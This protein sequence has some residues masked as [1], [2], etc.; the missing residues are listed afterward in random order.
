MDITDLRSEPIKSKMKP[1][2]LYRYYDGDILVGKECVSCGICFTIDNYHNAKD[3]KD[4]TVSKCKQCV[5]AQVSSSYA[6]RYDKTGA[7]VPG[8]V[9][10]VT[11]GTDLEGMIAVPSRRYRGWQG[12][13][14]YNS[15]GKIV[16]K[17]CPEC[18]KAI[19][20]GLFDRN[21]GHTDGLSTYCKKCNGSLNKEYASIRQDNDPNYAKNRS[22]KSYEKYFLRTDEEI[23]IKRSS[24]HPEGTKR[25]RVCR[26][27]RKFTEY[28]IARGR[29]DGLAQDCK[30]C[31]VTKRRRVCEEY[32]KIA[33]I[34]L[35]C[36]LDS[37]SK[38]FEEIDHVV[39]VTL[40]G[41]DDL[42]NLLPI[43]S[44]HNKRKHGTL[45]PLWLM[46]DYPED[47]RSTMETVEGYGIDTWGSYVPLVN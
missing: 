40:D 45:L 15:D 8:W 43:C 32:W 10:E 27:T 9:E 26:G 19:A 35:V 16:G 44:H 17:V 2:G 1:T 14:F 41:S 23:A 42:S 38:G 33:G 47:Y 4:G 30:E 24:I 12:V 25:C 3:K 29:A 36:Y 20:V 31:K 37:C 13:R 7:Q 22:K 18:K 46:D 28:D 6:D 21:L 11:Q 39:P 34:P 5:S